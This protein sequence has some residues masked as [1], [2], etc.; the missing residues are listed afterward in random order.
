MDDSDLGIGSKVEQV[1]GPKGGPED[2][3]RAPKQEI[4]LLLD[5]TGIKKGGDGW[6]DII[7]EVEEIEELF[8]QGDR[9][10]KDAV[11]DAMD[12]RDLKLRADVEVRGY[13]PGFGQSVAENIANSISRLEQKIDERSEQDPKYRSANIMAGFHLLQMDEALIDNVQGSKDFALKTEVWILK[14]LQRLLREKEPDKEVID[15]SVR[16]EEER[17]TPKQKFDNLLKESGVPYDSAD[18]IMYELGKMEYLFD[19]GNREARAAVGDTI[20]LRRLTLKKRIKENQA[21]PNQATLE[22]LGQDISRLEQQI[23]QSSEREPEYKKVREKVEEGIVMIGVDFGE[24]E[25][26]PDQAREAEYQ[27]YSQFERLLKPKQG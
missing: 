23:D 1:K 8:D 13:S 16:L 7:G 4:G 26:S 17:L 6:W 2:E 25:V 3:R 19:E 24:V 21:K 22:R 20:K 11:R 12:L 5:E 14:Q 18:D 27:L 10:A 15:S 9:T